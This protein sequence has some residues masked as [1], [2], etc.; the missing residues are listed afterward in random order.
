MLRIPQNGGIVQVRCTGGIHNEKA[1]NYSD[2]TDSYDPYRFRK[3]KKSTP[4][5]I[6]I[7]YDK[8][9]R[10]SRH[11]GQNRMLLPL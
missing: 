1:V 3:G 10:K 9:Y 6:E 7:D 8:T 5:E 4:E 11:S 2:V